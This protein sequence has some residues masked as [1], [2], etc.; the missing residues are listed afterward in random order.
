MLVGGIEVG[1]KPRHLS[2]LDLGHVLYGIGLQ[3]CTGVGVVHE[4]EFVLEPVLDLVVVVREA[5]DVLH[6]ESEERVSLRVWPGDDE[7]AAGI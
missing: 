4:S 3:D 1:N 7:V 5:G 2:Q 6:G